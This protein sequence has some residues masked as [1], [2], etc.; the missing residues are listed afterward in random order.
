LSIGLAR[1]LDIAADSLPAVTDGTLKV[2]VRISAL[3]QLLASIAGETVV[4]DGTGPTLAI[5]ITSPSD[6]DLVTVQM[7]CVL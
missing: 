5:K 2:G 7:P 4:L 6:T 1:Q 3:A